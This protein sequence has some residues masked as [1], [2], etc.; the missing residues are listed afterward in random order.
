MG[1]IVFVLVMVAVIGTI[2]SGSK[3]E[4]CRA[5]KRQISRRAAFCPHCGNR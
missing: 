2:A 1:F 4:K 3:L 5:C